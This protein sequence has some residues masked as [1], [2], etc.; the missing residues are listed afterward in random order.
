MLNKFMFL[1][2]HELKTEFEE[3]NAEAEGLRMELDRKQAELEQL[4]KAKEELDLA[5]ANSPLKQQAS[6]NF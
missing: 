6:W 4:A 5:L 1:K 3:V 2:E